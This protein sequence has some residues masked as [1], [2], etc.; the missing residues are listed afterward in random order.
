MRDLFEA[1]D[2][3]LFRVRDDCWNEGC[4]PRRKQLSRK[5]GDRFRSHGSVVEIEV[6]IPI[7]LEIDQTWSKPDI[8]RILPTLGAFERLDGRYRRWALSDGT[9]PKGSWS[10]WRELQTQAESLWCI[11]RES[12][13]LVH[14]ERSDACPVD[15]GLRDERRQHRTLAGCRRE[16][17]ANVQLTFE[18]RT[19]SVANVVRGL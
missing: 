3:L 12:Y 14:I 17:N 4:A 8:L 2:H 13:V 5:R 19:Q 18:A 7:D 10:K 16:D 6:S 1:I 11:L 15:P 9:A